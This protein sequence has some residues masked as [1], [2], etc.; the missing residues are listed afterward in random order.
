MCHYLKTVWGTKEATG[1]TVIDGKIGQKMTGC[2]RWR[3]SIPLEDIKGEI[4]FTN[5]VPRV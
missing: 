3:R 1:K 2:N 4:T 5:A